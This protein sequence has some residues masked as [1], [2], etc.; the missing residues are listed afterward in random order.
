M[1]KAQEN[2]KMGPGSEVGAFTELGVLPEKGLLAIGKNALIRSHS[3]I[4]AGCRI[5]D[6]FRT[7]HGVMVRENNRIGDNVSI[8]T[9]SVIERDSVIGSGVRIH[10]SVFIPEYT[11]IKDNAWIGPGVVMTNADFPLGRRTKEL[12]K[13][14]VIEESAKIGANA[15]ILPGVRIGKG[16]LV[17]AGSVVTRDVPAGSVVAGNPAKVMKSVSELRYPDGGKPY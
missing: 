4:Y 17:G 15:T 12:L 1:G 2:V 14:P 3:V 7:G 9:H 16:S 13:G 11:E 8:G 5:G 6:N 10:S